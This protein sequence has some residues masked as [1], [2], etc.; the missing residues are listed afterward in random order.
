VL[1]YRSTP[2]CPRLLRHRTVGLAGVMGDSS[3]WSLLLLGVGELPGDS[4]RR[5]SR[6]RHFCGGHWSAAVRSRGSGVPSLVSPARY[7]YYQPRTVHTP[8][9]R[10]GTISADI[11]A[12][13]QAK[14]QR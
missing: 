12:S 4:D 3:P 6:A 9:R 7:P 10:P 8:F 11:V 5:G 2:A 13:P 1:G 14:A